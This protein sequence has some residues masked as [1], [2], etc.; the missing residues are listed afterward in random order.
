MQRPIK[1]CNRA[2]YFV[3]NFTYKDGTVVPMFTVDTFHELSQLIGYVKYINKDDDIYYR[4]QNENYDMMRPA[5]YRIKID[6]AKKVKEPNYSTKNAALNKYINKHKDTFKKLGIPEYA[7]E[8][9]LQHYGFNTA[10]LDVVDNIWVALWFGLYMEEIK[11]NEKQYKYVKKQ[12]GDFQY[13]YLLASDAKSERKTQNGLYEGN[14][15]LLIDLRK[16][17]PS[18]FIRPHSQQGL[19][20]RKKKIQKAIDKNMSQY[21]ACIIRLSTKNVNNWIGSSEIMSPHF[22]YPSPFY[23]DGYASLLNYVSSTK[24]ETYNIG[25]ITHIS[26]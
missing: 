8:P 18:Q 21:V 14:E 22:I 12:N 10:W 19:L 7:I 1:W 11:N 2:K 13:F 16:A 24:D 20:I 23:D 3:S 6:K 5:L 9:S 25:S 4:G 26:Y 15:T 17:C